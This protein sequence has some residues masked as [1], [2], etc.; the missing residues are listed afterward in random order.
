MSFYIWKNFIILFDNFLL[1]FF[2]F[3]FFAD[4]MIKSLT[5]KNLNLCFQL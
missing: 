3:R 4:S 5:L 1:N 2:C